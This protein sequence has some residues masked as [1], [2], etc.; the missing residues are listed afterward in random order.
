MRHHKLVREQRLPQP[1]EEAFGFFADALNLEAITPPWL[2]FEV[3]TPGPIEMRP[4][5]LID[6]RLRIHG[7]PVRWHARIDVWEP[8]RRFVD[9]QLRG[10]YRVWH[11]TH[12]FEADGRGGTTMRDVVRYALPLGILGALAHVLFVRRDVERIFDHRRQAIERLAASRA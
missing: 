5:T 7:V 10:P 8:G 1:P 12:Q 2:Q 4:G 3:T 9:R 6:Y 11:H